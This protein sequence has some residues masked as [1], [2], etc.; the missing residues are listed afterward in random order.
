MFMLSRLDLS[1]LYPIMTALG[2]ALATL[3]SAW[4]FQERIS[5]IRLAGILVVMM[6]VFL[7]SQSQQ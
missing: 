2:L 1:F 3:V 6:G 4:I 7:V 5:L